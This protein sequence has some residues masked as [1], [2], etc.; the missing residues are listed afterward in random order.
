MG[1]LQPRAGS[2]PK[3]PQHGFDLETSALGHRGN[4]ST[5][6]QGLSSLLLELNQCRSIKRRRVGNAGAA[7]PRSLQENQWIIARW[8]TTRVLLSTGQGPVQLLGD[9]TPRCLLGGGHSLTHPSTGTILPYRL[10]LTA[11]N[12]T[13]AWP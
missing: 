9:G 3:T 2:C 11:R 13:P 1:A 10:V 6:G 12:E 5:D 8:E 4:V 7:E